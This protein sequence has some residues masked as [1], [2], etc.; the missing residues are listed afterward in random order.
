M[1]DPPKFL[2]FKLNSYLRHPEITFPAEYAHE[3]S[4]VAKFSP[5]KSNLGDRG[6]ATGPLTH[7]ASIK[8]SVPPFLEGFTHMHT[9]A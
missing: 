8:E 4:Y 7:S 3:H 9:C 1:W 2:K 5:K 6:I